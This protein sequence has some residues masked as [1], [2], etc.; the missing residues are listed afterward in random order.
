MRTCIV[1]D[2][3]VLVPGSGVCVAV[4][5]G[6]VAAVVRV[7]FR[8]LVVVEAVV[9]IRV[10]VVVRTKGRLIAVVACLL[11][12]LAKGTYDSL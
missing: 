12:C 11:L 10:R 5:G 2:V 8:E 3:K 9:A 4:L 1:T 6:C 7:R